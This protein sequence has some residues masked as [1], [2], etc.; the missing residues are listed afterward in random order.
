MPRPVFF[1]HTKE[2]CGACSEL[3]KPK[4]F[5]Y[6]TGLIKKANPETDIRIIK[7]PEG[8]T[9][10]N[11]SDDYVQFG[12]ISWAPTYAVT[13][14]TNAGSGGDP[15]KVEVYS[16]RPSTNLK[17][18]VLQ[19]QRPDLKQWLDSVLDPKKFT[20]SAPVPVK[21]TNLK[22]VEKLVSSVQN[23]SGVVLPPSVPKSDIQRVCHSFRVVP[24]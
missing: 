8:W 1:I 7:H 19:A 17:G 10:N 9:K 13:S 5:S 15:S 12:I 24:L 4:N 6:L 20:S 14:D 22:E 21:R 16:G 23:E 3:M 11:T 18:K 2:K